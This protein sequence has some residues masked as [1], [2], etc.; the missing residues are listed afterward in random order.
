MSSPYFMPRQN[1]NLHESCFKGCNANFRSFWIEMCNGE[2]LHKKGEKMKTAQTTNKCAM[3]SC[4][5][6]N[7]VCNASKKI[8]K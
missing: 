7:D 3:T 1:L 5:K 2:N 8:K 4:T 6:K